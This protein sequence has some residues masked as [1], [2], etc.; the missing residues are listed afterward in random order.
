M[1]VDGDI[2]IWGIH[3]IGVRC[4]DKWQDQFTIPGGCFW[5]SSLS[6]KHPGSHVYCYQWSIEANNSCGLPTSTRP[7]WWCKPHW[8]KWIIK[9]F[10]LHTNLSCRNS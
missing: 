1:A 4:L 5:V 2:A 9:K 7:K 3:P 6:R 8:K 10:Y